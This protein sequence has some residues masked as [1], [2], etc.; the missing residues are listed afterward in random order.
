MLLQS[1]TNLFL[2]YQFIPISSACDNG[3]FGE[4]IY[5]QRTKAVNA[6]VNPQRL[7]PFSIKFLSVLTEVNI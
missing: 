6:T 1:P 4:S 5:Y 2:K 7:N 3:E